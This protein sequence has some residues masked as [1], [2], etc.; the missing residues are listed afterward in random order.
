M[1]W[2]SILSRSHPAL[3]FSLILPTS[4]AALTLNGY[5]AP[6]TLPFLHAAH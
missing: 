3:Y 5:F 4:G 1:A 2:V 6:F